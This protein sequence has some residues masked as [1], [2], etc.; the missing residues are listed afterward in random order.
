MAL[1]EE[2]RARLN[3]KAQQKQSTVG[4]QPQQVVY[5]PPPSV[6]QTNVKPKRKVKGWVIA[7]VV[8]VLIAAIGGRGNRSNSSS[9]QVRSNTTQQVSVARET[10]ENQTASN[11]IAVQEPVVDTTKPQMNESDFKSSCQEFNYKTIARNPDAYIGQNFKVNVKIFSTANGGLFAGY[12][13]YY[14]AFTKMELDSEYFTEDYYM[15]D[16]IFIIDE[17]DKNSPSYLKVLDDDIIT[18]YCTFEGM[19]STK[20]ALTNTN[21]EEIALHMYFADLISE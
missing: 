6:Q 14:K 20:N 7:A 12:D 9:N 8:V 15:G 19:V 17:Q 3:A 21:S 4:N 1:T 13:K 18:A 5:T 10:T 16:M 11:E 2:Q